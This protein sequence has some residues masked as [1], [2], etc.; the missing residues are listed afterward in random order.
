M[1][2]IYSPEQSVR[3]EVV[4][5]EDVC[6]HR[7]AEVEQRQRL[8]EGGLRVHVVLERPQIK[9]GDE[10]C[11]QASVHQAHLKEVCGRHHHRLEDV[12]G[13][14]RGDV[15]GDPAVDAEGAC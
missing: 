3:T 13:A 7:P 4:P 15:D 12:D 14:G 8:V 5:I 11:A 2:H 6:G 10:R 1:D 9:P